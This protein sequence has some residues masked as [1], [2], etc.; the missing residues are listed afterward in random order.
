[1]KVGSYKLEPV[2]FFVKD[3]GTSEETFSSVEEA[4]ERIISLKKANYNADY[5][6]FYGDIIQ[7]G[8][9]VRY[10]AFSVLPVKGDIDLAYTNSKNMTELKKQ[11]KSQIG[12]EKNVRLATFS[13]GEIKSASKKVPTKT[14][15]FVAKVSKNDNDVNNLKITSTL[16][17]KMSTAELEKYNGLPDAKYIYKKDYYATDHDTNTA[18]YDIEVYRVLERASSLE[19][20]DEIITRI[21]CDYTMREKYGLDDDIEVSIMKTNTLMKSTVFYSEDKFY[22][23]PKELIERYR[24]RTNDIELMETLIDDSYTNLRSNVLEDTEKT[25]DISDKTLKDK[26]DRKA[27]ILRLKKSLKGEMRVSKN[28][29]EEK[30]EHDLV[31]HQFNISTVLNPLLYSLIYKNTKTK[32]VNYS[33]MRQLASIIK[34]RDDKLNEMKDEYMDNLVASVM[35]DIESGYLTE[36]TKFHIL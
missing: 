16:N 34:N 20:M 3:N 10:T 21:Q 36:E 29:M 17:D 22:L 25:L 26:E 2:Y 1:M 27:K 30:R 24:N 14:V 19:A 32:E 8:V 18:L 6:V 31:M 15:V 12:T 9:F 5:G 11:F 7:V 35:R 4:N 28:L 33:L 13:N 23:N